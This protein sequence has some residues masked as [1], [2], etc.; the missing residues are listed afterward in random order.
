MT[1][2]IERVALRHA[3]PA[4]CAAH[5]REPRGDDELAL[6]GVDTRSAV[7]LLQRLAVGLPCAVDELGASDRDALLAALHRALWGD[8]IVS[9][10]HCP[11]CDADY[12]LAFEL[13]ALQRDLAQRTEPAAVDA[14]RVLRTAGGERFVLPCAADEE[15]AALLGDTGPARLARLIAGDDVADPDAVSA[16]LDALA[17]IIDVE[18]DT[19]CAECGHPQLARFDLQGFVLQRLLD[20][21][22]GVLDDL[23]ALAA[24]YGWALPDILA[25]PRSLRRSLVQ[26]LGGS[27]TAF[28]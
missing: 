22:D 12:D 21:R 11:A 27:A 16:R 26:R 28:G 3:A 7:Q 1:T 5:L 20:E 14:P 9:T 23:H 15:A 8:R 24:G 4:P 6:A 2:S 17:A 13:G 19:R 10:L 25:L 18:L